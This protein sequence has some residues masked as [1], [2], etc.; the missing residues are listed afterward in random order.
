MNVEVKLLFGTTV[1]VTVG[2]WQDKFNLKLITIAGLT[3]HCVND[4]FEFVKNRVHG[5]SAPEIYTTLYGK[6][7]KFYQETGV[8]MCNPTINALPP[9]NFDCRFTEFVRCMELSAKD[10][11][12]AMEIYK[13]LHGGAPSPYV[14]SSGISG[15]TLYCDNN[16]ISNV[17]IK[18][19]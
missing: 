5:I 7:L 13:L 11:N 1:Q 6:L 16:N 19:K 8:H 18:G 3:N 9:T 2:V 12:K 17:T 10:I 14:I 4:A 15:A